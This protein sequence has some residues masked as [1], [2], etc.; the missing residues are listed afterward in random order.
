[1]ISFQQL[2]CTLSSQ[3]LLSVNW[4][5]SFFHIYAEAD[6]HVSGNFFFISGNK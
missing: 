5:S 2:F 1:M 3:F 4:D 6:R